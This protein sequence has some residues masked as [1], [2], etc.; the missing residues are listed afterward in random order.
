[1]LLSN[2]RAFSRYARWASP[3]FSRCKGNAAKQL[4]W[5]PYSPSSIKR[6]LLSPSN[7]NQFKPVDKGSSCS[8]SSI[9]KEVFP[10]WN[11][12]TASCPSPAKSFYISLQFPFFKDPRETGTHP[13]E[14]PPL[15]VTLSQTLMLLLLYGQA[16]NPTIQICPLI[17]PSLSVLYYQF[18][19]LSPVQLCLRVLKRG[20]PWDLG[21]TRR[22]RGTQTH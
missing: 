8:F 13:I 6:A 1:M 14:T 20:A 11:Q 19:P 10:T 15:V 5:D 2:K 7:C 9:Y 22:D 3:P 12:G 21:M 4:T 18:L 16:P 17:T